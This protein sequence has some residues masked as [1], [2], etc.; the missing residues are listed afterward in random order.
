M[1]TEKSRR[2]L[3]SPLLPDPLNQLGAGHTGE[4][5]IGDDDGR[6]VRQRLGQRFL[7]AGRDRRRETMQRQD[8]RDVLREILVVVDH[9]HVRFDLH[10]P[11][12]M[13]AVRASYQRLPAK[14]ADFARAP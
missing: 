11:L 6:P 5:V 13:T 7:G 2:E 10:D 8:L 1:S 3:L 14:C 4:A 12:N 9:E